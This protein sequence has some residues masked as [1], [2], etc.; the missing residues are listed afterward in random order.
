MFVNV[1][2][3]RL[4]LPVVAALV[5]QLERLEMERVEGAYTSAGVLFQIIAARAVF[6]EK[7]LELLTFLL[8]RNGEIP[9]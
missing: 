2:K 9:P 7:F 8:L 3:R 5:G 4:L 6:L 1:L